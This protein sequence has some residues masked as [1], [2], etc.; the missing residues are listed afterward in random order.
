M[1]VGVE[2]AHKI[3]MG[4][5]GDLAVGPLLHQVKNVGG[6]LLEF[7]NGVGVAGV[8]GHSDGG[9][10][11]GQVHIYA[12]VVVGHIGGGKLLIR[13]RA[14]VESKVVLHLFVGGPDGGPTGGLGGHHVNA[15]AELHRQV[16]DARSHKLHHLVFY[17]AALVHLTDDAQGHVLG[18]DP[19][20]GLASEIDGDDLR[21]GNVVGAAYQ[22]LG[23]LAAALA[24]SHGAQGAVACVGVG[25]QDH[26]SAAGHHL[27]VVAVDDG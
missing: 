26:P 13:L 5:L 19:I 2:L 11:G 6:I 21:I 10:H 24:H 23:Q 16:F 9:L 25:A 22:L 8:H 27:S 15:V 12:A 4:G 14:A 1:A 3:Q 18:T 7:S 20:F 17:I